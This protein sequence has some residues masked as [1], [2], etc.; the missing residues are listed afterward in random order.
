M[1]T[2][3]STRGGATITP[4]DD[5]MTMPATGNT[6][7]LATKNEKTALP[8]ISPSTASSSSAH[9]N[10]KM[11]GISLKTNLRIDAALALGLLPR[12]H[13]VLLTTTTSSRTSNIGGP[14][15]TAPAA[16]ATAS[17]AATAATAANIVAD[18]I[19]TG[20]PQVRVITTDSVGNMDMNMEQLQEEQDCMDAHM[21]RNNQNNVEDQN[22][23][24]DGFYA[25][26]C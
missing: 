7:Q 1:A 16:S 6:A 22:E 23:D 14:I 19:L 12:D 25:I 15:T 20:V 26:V 11:V 10:N 17:T 8:L 18:S 24:D 5:I 4:N 3:A 21:Q 13:T 2:V 9:S